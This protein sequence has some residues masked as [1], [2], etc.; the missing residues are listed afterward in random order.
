MIFADRARWEWLPFFL[1]RFH[2]TV[3]HFPIALLLLAALLEMLQ[4]ASCGRWRFP[5]AA[6]LFLGSLS[7]VTAMALGWLLMEADAVTGVLAERHRQGGIVVAILA[8]AALFV[9]LIPAG[10]TRRVGQWSYRALLLATCIMLLRASHDGGTL[11]HGEDYLTEYAPWRKPAPPVALAFPT[12]KPIVQWDV[13][14]HVVTPILQTRCY[15]CHAAKNAKGGLVLDSWVGLQRGGKNGAVLVAGQPEKS[16]L[17]ER[18]NLPPEQKEHMPPRRKPQ[19]TPEEMAL[20]RRWIALGAPGQG[21]P[22]RHQA[23]Q[24]PAGS[25]RAVA[26]PLANRRTGGGAGAEGD[27][28]CR[29]GETPLRPGRH[30]GKIADEVPAY[31]ILRIAAVRRP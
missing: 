7:A 19:P 28:F 21:T 6:I 8:V 20:L 2:P 23:R 10:E 12:D 9:R 30:R 4:I 3:L 1:G 15:E 16:P 29:R 13:Y 26:S 25:R 22:R 11:T 18:M 14:A 27:R 5:V 17:L 31:F 24:S